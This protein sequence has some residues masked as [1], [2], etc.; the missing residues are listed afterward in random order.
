M[1]KSIKVGS[2]M[3]K[4]MAKAGKQVSN[5]RL[6]FTDGRMVEGEWKDGL[7]DGP[8]TFYYPTGKRVKGTWVQGK[9]DKSTKVVEG[10]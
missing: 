5:N 9:F 3:A 1:E 2:S 4:I 7:Q 10:E 6:T 8:G